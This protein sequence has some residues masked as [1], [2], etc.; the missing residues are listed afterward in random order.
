VIDA[1]SERLTGE[2]FDRD[3]RQAARGRVLEAVVEEF[4]GAPF[5]RRRPPKTAGREEFGR[6]FAK[7]FLQRCGRADKSDIIATATAFTTRSITDAVRRFLPRGKFQEMIVAGGGAKNPMLMAMLADGLKA[8]GMKLR[9]SDEFGL[10]AAAKEAAAFA[11][12]A[13]ETWHRRPSNVPSATGAKRAAIL[14]KISYA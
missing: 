7:K 6:E 10:P 12:L 5:F 3:G 9:T 13:H 2:R 11:L 1:L 14:G 4:L 8:M